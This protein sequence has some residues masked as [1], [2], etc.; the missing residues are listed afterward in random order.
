MVVL[1]LFANDSVPKMIGA[2]TG[3][4]MAYRAGP[5]F[6]AGFENILSF[7]FLFVIWVDVGTALVALT[8][9]ADDSVSKMIGAETGDLMAYRAG[10]N[11]LCRG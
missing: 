10:P 9:F 3:D 8:L 11:F 1:G 6:Y 4:L 2:E 7:C 5:T